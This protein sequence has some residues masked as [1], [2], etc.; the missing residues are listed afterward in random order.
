M[1]YLICDRCEGY[2]ELQPGESS[3]NFDLICNYG[4]ELKFHKP[5]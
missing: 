2:Y 3:E 1:G 5:N 4:G